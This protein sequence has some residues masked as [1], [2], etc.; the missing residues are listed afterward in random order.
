M[1]KRIFL[2]LLSVSVALCF[3]ESKNTEILTPGSKEVVIVGKITVHTNDKNREFF[4]KSW[5]VKDFSKADT[6]VA[7]DEVKNPKKEMPEW[8]E[9]LQGEYFLAKRIVKD[10]QVVS[11]SRFAWCFYSDY[12]FQVAVPLNF[13][14]TIPDGEKYVY[15]GDFDYYLD[16]S[17]FRPVKITVSDSFDL[18]KEFLEA[19]YGVPVD[20]CRVE[21]SNLDE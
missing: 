20:L 10:R 4:A 2:L 9:Y 14:A 16:G 8:R 18:A 13:K 6:Y 3:A 5:G 11:K 7:F 15:I 21:I 19:T 17:D 1:K 12:D